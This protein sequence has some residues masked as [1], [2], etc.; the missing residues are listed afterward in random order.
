MHFSFSYDFS[1][2]L[3]FK[4]N[5]SSILILLNFLKIFATVS[6]ETKILMQLIQNFCFLI[7]GNLIERIIQSHVQIIFLIWKR[8]NFFFFFICFNVA[9]LLICSTLV[10]KAT[11]GSFWLLLRNVNYSNNLCIKSDKINLMGPTLQ[12]LF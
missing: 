7:S 4:C 8:I 10:E 2:V 9:R 11:A 12:L 5:A 6:H 1:I 3:S